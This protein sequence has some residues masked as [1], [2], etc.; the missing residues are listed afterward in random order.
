MG[1]MRRSRERQAAQAAADK[2]DAAQAKYFKTSSIGSSTPGLF[3]LLKPRMGM[4]G[5]SPENTPTRITRRR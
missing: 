1:A 2:F 4:A 3:S 5:A